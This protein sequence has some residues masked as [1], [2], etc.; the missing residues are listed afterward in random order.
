MLRRVAVRRLQ[1]GDRL[2]KTVL[3]RDGRVLLTGGVILKEVY[4]QRLKEM[5][6]NA[7]YIEDDLLPGVEVLDVI[8]DQTRVEA[9]EQV[10]SAF[11]TISAGDRPDLATVRAVVNDIIDEILAN[12]KLLINLNDIR[13]RD[14]GAFRHSVNVCVLSTL[15][16]VTLGLNQLRLRDLAIGALLHDIGKAYLPA[17]LLRA[18]R[19]GAGAAPAE[20]RVHAENGFE[21]LRRCD[22]VSV[23]AAHVAYQHHERPD[24]AGFPRGL[25]A[26][27][28]HPFAHVV[29]ACNAYDHLTAEDCEG[30]GLPSYQALKLLAAGR[31]TEYDN[32]AVC[33]LAA[34]VAPFPVGSCLRL[35][36]GALAVVLEVD[37]S[38]PDRPVVRLISDPAGGACVRRQVDLGREAG[39]DLGEVMEM[40]SSW[41]GAVH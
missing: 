29:A 40:L 19:R 28:I 33:A 11:A 14:D 34:N 24:G 12:R 39:V 35:K 9:V 15:S 4:I 31:G 10:R 6:V 36:S 23:P 8:T 1:P 20:L 16:G 37:R 27:G 5:C 13:S 25:A 21:F 18:G 3:D 41:A 32:D 17:E 30:D 2:G 7:V 22:G 26:T 38:A